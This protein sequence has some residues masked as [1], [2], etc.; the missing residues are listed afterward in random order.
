M[1]RSRRE[2]NLLGSASL[3][4]VDRMLAACRSEASSTGESAAGIVAAA[5][6]LAGSSIE[7]L[8]RSVGLTHSATVR[9]VDKLEARGDLERRPGPDRRSVA[10]G[11]VL[12]ARETALEEMLGALTAAE[13]RELARLH[14]KLLAGVVRAGATT[15]NVCRLCDADSCGHDAGRCPVT[16][17]ARETRR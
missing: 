2:A 14:E 17:T 4:V 12:A 1:H 7:A 5:T 9:L 8:S 6:F 13:R 16:E 3:A 11:G 10:A 15:T